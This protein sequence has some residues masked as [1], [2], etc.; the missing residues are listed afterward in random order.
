VQFL[1]QT[2][3][4]RWA[5]LHPTR[6]S[7]WKSREK[8]FYCRKKIA[9]ACGFKLYCK[10]YLDFQQLKTEAFNRRWAKTEKE[11]ENKN[12][13]V[14]FVCRMDALLHNCASKCTEGLP[15]QLFCSV[16]MWARPIEM[17][18]MKYFEELDHFTKNCDT[19]TSVKAFWI[20]LPAWNSW[21]CSCFSWIYLELWSC[22]PLIFKWNLAVIVLTQV[23]IFLDRSIFWNIIRFASFRLSEWHNIF[24]NFGLDL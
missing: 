5:K 4:S 14:Q 18:E 21:S 16:R 11:L 23:L 3:N 2:K 8:L 12:G 22:Y 1:G 20:P 10:R 17:N 15:M 13:N 9:I 6:W 19:A 7:L 24:L